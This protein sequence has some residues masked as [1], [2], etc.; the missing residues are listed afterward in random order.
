MAKDENK[1][2]VRQFLEAWVDAM[3]TGN[4]ST[5]E[6]LLSEDMTLWISGLTYHGR[7]ALLERTRWTGATFDM[8]A[9]DFEVVS[10]VADGD[11]VIV[12]MRLEMWPSPDAGFAGPVRNRPV[13]VFEVRDGMVAAQREYVD[14][15]PFSHLTDQLSQP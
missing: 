4:F 8:T 11:M 1:L 14:R 7:E 9:G 5:Y 10:V 6:A 3:V 2:V 13:H 12:E 15:L